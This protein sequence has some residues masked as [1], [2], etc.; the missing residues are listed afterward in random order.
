M[1]KILS[2]FMSQ[3][4]RGS[5][6]GMTASKGRSGQILRSK[7][8]PV[9]PRSYIQQQKRFLLQSLNHH[10]LTLDPTYITQWNDFAANWTVTDSLGQ[11][12]HLTGLNWFISLNTRL[13]ALGSTPHDAPPLNPNCAYNP[14]I[15]AHQ[16]AGGDPITITFDTVPTA[17][18]AIWCRWSGAL[19]KTS[20]FKKKSLKQRLIIRST[21]T[22]PKTAILYADLTPTI[23]R[24]QFELFSVDEYGRG[25]SV[26]RFDVYPATA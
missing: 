5:V 26:Q 9:Q 4:A 18:Q 22:S 7:R 21:D 15:L 11:S 8:S 16:A 3:E 25:G 10:F 12:I 23:S 14:V 1:A 13:V 20:S 24:Y 19:P 2:P 17:W 6:G